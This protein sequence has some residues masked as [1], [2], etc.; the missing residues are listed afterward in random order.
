[1]FTIGS[2]ELSNIEPN[3]DF[4]DLTGR[5]TYIDNGHLGQD[6]IVAVLDTGV[7]PHPE[8]EDRLIPGI[9]LNH[10]YGNKEKYQDD[11]G[12]GTHV[13][14]TIAGK[15][16]GVAPK[17]KILPVK[18]LDGMGSGSVDDIINGLKYVRDWRGSNGEKVNVVNMS[19][20]CSGAYLEKTPD[21]MEEFKKIIHELVS[22][23][24]ICMC[25][26]GNSG[27]EETNYPAHFYDSVAVGAVDI[28]KKAAYF[29]TRNKEVDVC[30]VGVNICSASYKGGYVTMSGTSMAT[31]VVSGIAALMISRYKSIFNKDIPET[32]LYEMIKYNTIDIGIEGVDVV[33][34]AGFCSLNTNPIRMELLIGSNQV[35]V[36][37][38]VFE[39]AEPATIINGSTMVGI[40]TPFESIGGKVTWVG[41][42]KKVIID[43]L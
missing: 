25:A 7:S 39:M 30:Q 29:T 43:I 14:G 10:L 15:T 3:F 2:F 4:L 42:E 27:K 34:G 20:S 36:G 31:P 21:K 26:S 6:V 11:Q 37:D 28:N 33:T 17:A 8:F 19:L 22:M 41:S 1:M 35:V 13:A 40:R 9:N 23:D 18:I 5:R 32:A 38:K 16:C 24:I 12:H